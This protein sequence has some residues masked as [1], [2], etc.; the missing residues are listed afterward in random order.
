MPKIIL[1]AR[2]THWTRN[3]DSLHSFCI[4]LYTHVVVYAI[5]FC[6]ILSPVKYYCTGEGFSVAHSTKWPP[7]TTSPSFKAKASG[8]TDSQG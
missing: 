3:Q 6:I 7:S 4:F 2:K 5:W 8:A 1:E